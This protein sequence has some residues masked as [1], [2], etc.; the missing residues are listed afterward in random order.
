MRSILLAAASVGA[1]C[2]GSARANTMWNFS[3]DSG[4]GWT[5]SGVIDVDN[6]GY[7]ISGSGTATNP[8]IPGGFAITLAPNA[9]G[10]AGTTLRSWFGDDEIFDN[11][12]GTSA[13]VIDGNGLG[14]IGGSLLPGNSEYARIVNIYSGPDQIYEAGAIDDSDPSDM[15][16]SNKFYNYTNAAITFSAAPA[17]EPASLALLGVGAFGLVLVRRYRAR[18]HARRVAI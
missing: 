3:A 4:N 6:L 1:L 9:N 15:S 5:A 12:V 13:P 11:Y 7:A 2:V 8:S 16:L 17:P 14:F 10:L 18:R